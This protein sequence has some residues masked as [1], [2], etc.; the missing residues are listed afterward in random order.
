MLTKKMNISERRM[1]GALLE[2]KLQLADCQNTLKCE[3]QLNPQPPI[4]SYAFRIKGLAVSKSGHAG[5]DC[6]R[7]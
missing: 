6:C 5:V 4:F 7:R 3:L 2:F 1:K